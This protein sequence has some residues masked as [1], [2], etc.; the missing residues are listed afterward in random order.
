M[1]ADATRTF[2]DL[3][4]QRLDVVEISGS[5]W[6]DLPW[7]SRVALQYPEFDLCDASTDLP[8]YDLVIC[9]QVLEHVE[10]PITAVKTLRRLCKPSGHVFVS[11]P[12]LLRI[13]D[14]PADYWR[15]T[16]AGLLRLLHCGGLEPLWVR[17]WGNR[18]VVRANFDKWAIALPWSSLRNEMDLPVVVWALAQS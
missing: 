12:F 16:P 17:S 15:F 7:K 4:P 8:Q 18:H 10:D 13:H 11:T 14:R 5:F 3:G 6:A 2:A 1:N 9:E